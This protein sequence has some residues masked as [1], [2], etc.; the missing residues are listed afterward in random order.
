MTDL[1]SSSE[2]IYSKTEESKNTLAC[3]GL[4]PIEFESRRERPLQRTQSCESFEAAGISLD[5]KFARGCDPDFDAIPFFQ[6]E[7][8]YDRGRKA[9]RQ[10][11]SPLCNPHTTHLKDIRKLQPI[12]KRETQSEPHRDV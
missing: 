12:W 4:F 5:L 11:V 7:F 6:F 9:D 1:G 3:V 2:R 8:R 10:A